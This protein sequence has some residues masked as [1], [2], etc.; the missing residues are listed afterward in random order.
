M[1]SFIKGL[2]SQ[3]GYISNTTKK[4]LDLYDKSKFTEQEKAEVQI[5]ASKNHY[6]H[7]KET[8]NIQARLTRRFIAIVVTM[9]L[10]FNMTIVFLAMILEFISWNETSNF[11]AIVLFTRSFEL[12]KDVTLYIFIPVLGYYFSVS[13]IDKFKKKDK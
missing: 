8:N 5:D 9:I 11:K 6:E 10:L 1:F 13:L 3:E 4:G 12:L 2:F 7:V